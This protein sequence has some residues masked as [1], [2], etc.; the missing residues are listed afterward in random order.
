MGDLLRRGLMGHRPSYGCAW[1]MRWWL[2]WAGFLEAHLLVVAPMLA[3][4][5][6]LT[7]C[8]CLK[9][10][11]LA[12]LLRSSFRCV[13]IDGASL[14]TSTPAMGSTISRGRGKWV[15]GSKRLAQWAG[16]TTEGMLI[17]TYNKVS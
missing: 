14:F 17:R 1:S 7:R 6:L 5:L 13:Q 10:L 15:R 2:V 8:F 3:A 12:A 11:R 9:T 16:R 4:A